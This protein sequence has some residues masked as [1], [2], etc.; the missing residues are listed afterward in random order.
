MKVGKRG[1][2]FLKTKENDILTIIYVNTNELLKKHPDFK[3]SYI[4]PK[5]KTMKKKPHS[6]NKIW[7]AIFDKNGRDFLSPKDFSNSAFLKQMNKIS[8]E[9]YNYDDYPN[10]SE[11]YTKMKES[12]LDKLYTK[13][14]FDK[15]YKFIGNQL[16]DM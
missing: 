15:Q 14:W 1:C 12:D 13:K 5:T 11:L 6:P 16:K 9:I 10:P 2:L 7:F 4:N 3:L 8:S